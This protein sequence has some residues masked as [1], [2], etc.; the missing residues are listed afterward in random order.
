MWGICKGIHTH[1]YIYTYINTCI[2]IYVI[3]YWSAVWN[4]NLIFHILGMSSSQLLLTPSFFRGVGWNHQ[5]E[6]V[7]CWKRNG[8]IRHGYPWY[9][10]IPHDRCWKSFLKMHQTL[11]SDRQT[12]VKWDFW[13]CYVAAFSPLPNDSSL[14]MAMKREIERERDRE[15]ERV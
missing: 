13:A 1:I 5:P 6:Y 10:M 12:C 8:E 4:M 15:R 2:Y 14:E 7:E 9:H 3:Q 11:G